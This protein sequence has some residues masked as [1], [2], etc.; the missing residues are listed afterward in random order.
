MRAKCIG[1]KYLYS[2]E[3]NFRDK[4]ESERAR[5]KRKWEW[6]GRGQSRGDFFFFLLSFVWFCAVGMTMSCGKRSVWVYKW[7]ERKMRDW[8]GG[9]WVIEAVE[10]MVV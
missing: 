4:E 3:A 6:C 7:V 8:D 10:L 9:Q 2:A 5:K 1:K